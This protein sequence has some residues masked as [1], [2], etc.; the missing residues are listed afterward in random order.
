L[1]FEAVWSYDI[2]VA[3]Y[4]VF[5]SHKTASAVKTID[6]A[7]REYVGREFEVNILRRAGICSALI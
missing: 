7:A 4:K 5:V 3:D 1:K 2:H 6:L